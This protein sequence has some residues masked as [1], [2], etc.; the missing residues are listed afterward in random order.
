MQTVPRDFGKTPIR[1][2]GHVILIALIAMDQ[3]NSNVM[4]ARLVFS[5]LISERD[6]SILVLEASMVTI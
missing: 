6:V 3:I 1:T 5:R 2:V 4:P